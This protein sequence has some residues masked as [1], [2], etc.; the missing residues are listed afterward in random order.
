MSA[1]FQ[2]E[3]RTVSVT[4]S[5]MGA[6]YAVAVMETLVAWGARRILFYGWCGTVSPTLKV[7]DILV[8]ADALIDE[9]TSR[10]YA[11]DGNQPAEAVDGANDIVRDML[12]ANGISWR[13]GRIWTT[14]GV[15]RE[16]P[17][18]ISAAR[19]RGALAVDMETSALLSAG[20]FRGIPV[21][22]VLVVSD[23]LSGPA[24]QPGFHTALFRN[25]RRAICQGMV[26]LCRTPKK[27]T[28]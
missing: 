25:A 6:P 10:H 20:R 24:W 3:A 19:N 23:D 14:D 16:T 12:R 13:E 4:G 17:E 11:G 8:P 27:Q 9:G 15:Y 7:G 1:L 28:P 26:S 21:G 18:K 22:I 5:M 2:D